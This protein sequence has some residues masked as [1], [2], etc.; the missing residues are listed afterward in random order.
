[1]KNIGIFGH[2]Q[3]GKTSLN[4]ALLYKAGVITRKGKVE[5]GNTTT[6]FEPEEI[7]RGISINL[8]LSY[9]KDGDRR[10]NLIDTPGYSDFFG[11]VIY[12]FSVV[13]IC[14]LLISS[15]IEVCTE[16]AW[17]IAKE[18]NIPVVFFLN[19]IDKNAD[20]DS[21][22]EQAKKSLSKNIIPLTL[23]GEGGKRIIDRLKE[24]EKD[25][26][27]AVAESDDTLL[28]KYLEKGEISEE[29]FK[30]GLQKGIINR[31]IFPL[32]CGSAL[33]D[34]GIKELL[35]FFS[36]LPDSE[37]MP[38]V[39]GIISEKGEEIER[40][41]KENE[42]F[43]ARVFKTVL[44]PY[45]GKLTYF[46]IFSGK[47]SSNTG[48]Y[49]S[50]QKLKERFGQLF[51]LQGKK[52]EKV[53]EAKE[54]DIVAV[55]KL[56]ETKTGDTLCDL[57]HPILFPRIN[58]PEPSISFS[59]KVKE[60]GKE[61]KLGGAFSKIIQ[62]DPTVKVGRDVS[63][64]ETII[65]G[66][67]ELQLTLW[68]NR[69]SSQ[70]GVEVIKGI[71]RVAYRETITTTASA[72]GKY[73]RQ[74]GGHG[75]YGDAWIKVEP[76]ERG[77]GFEFVNKIVGGAIPRGYIPA[78]EKGVREAMEKGVLA[79][80]PLIDIRV[81]LYDG[82]YH[83]VDSSE[84]AFKIAGSM[85]LKKASSEAKPSLLEPIMNVEITAPQKFIGEIISDINSRRGR[86][87]NIDSSGNSQVIKAR[88][89][90]AEMSNYGTSLRSLTRGQTDYRAQF[91]HY[92][93]VPFSITEKIIEKAKEKE[94]K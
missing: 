49:N 29:E 7:E 62:V 94:G 80:Y 89:P 5:E 52:E 61:D 28:N 64:G 68:L 3:T 50:S 58:L 11:E 44:D 15:E 43:S 12:A 72:Q 27:E 26:E 13:D 74:T 23:P 18:R 35:D 90:L 83:P 30:T 88:I 42:P 34:V 57:A 2:S 48:A 41:R 67:G 14:L 87:L 76:L 39:Q 6:D 22:I 24:R 54:G 84:M 81:S 59:V 8:A 25:I 53:E 40:E 45:V 75:Q 9:L 38:K 93:F 17:Q 70:F 66:L 37:K 19:K 85:A 77:K 1:M 47:I 33:T 73:K 55:A 16:K 21:L 4:E 32:F 65:S 71:P 78:V 92:E 36:Y 60:K 91:S 69:L 63:T 82:S 51:F 20:Y 10:V 79:D 31:Q 86:V 46:R 56:T